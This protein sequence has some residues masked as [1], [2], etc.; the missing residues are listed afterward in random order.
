MFVDSDIINYNSSLKNDLSY[1]EEKQDNNIINL[2]KFNTLHKNNNNN[3]N[4]NTTTEYILKLEDDFIINRLFLKLD[5]DIY[6]EL[7]S[8]NDLIYS[9]FNTDII[10]KSHNVD[11]ISI[12]ILD[13]LILNNNVNNSELN[14]VVID[15][16]NFSKYVTSIKTGKK[17]LYIQ[18]KIT[19]LLN[20]KYDNILKD[21]IKDNIYIEYETY[22][23]DEVMDRDIFNMREKYSNIYFNSDIICINKDEDEI[24]FTYI[25]YDRDLYIYMYINSD[26][27]DIN[28]TINNVTLNN[29]TQI[30]Y[31]QIDVLNKKVYI[32]PLRYD[33]INNLDNLNCYINNNTNV[34]LYRKENKIYNLTDRYKT[35]S[36]KTDFNAY[37]SDIIIHRVSYYSV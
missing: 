5:L 26:Y 4:N 18:E 2:N 15:L 21:I 20:I 28:N 35:F 33:F 7:L 27:D 23:C 1:Y 9:L 31:Y 10:F 11:I 34:E 30:N 3:T 16:Y 19:L 37:N 6:E 17:G 12:G 24:N 32:I 29:D 14:K 13:S 8:N 36:L 25:D 22:N